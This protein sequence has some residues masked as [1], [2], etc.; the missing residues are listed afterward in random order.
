MREWIPILAGVLMGA[1]AH[2]GKTILN[3]GWPSFKEFAGYVLQLGMI[4]LIAAYGASLLKLEED[5]A[6]SVLAAV[7]ALAANE[8]IT[9]AKGQGK[10]FFRAMFELDGN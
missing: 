2:L 6:Q 9:L 10:K 3:S 8:V 1:C 4:G 7:L 5:L